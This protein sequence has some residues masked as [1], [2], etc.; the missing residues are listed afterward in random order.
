[1]LHLKTQCKTVLTY[2]FL[3]ELLLMFQT[4]V[5]TLTSSLQCEKYC[6]LIIT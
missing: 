3:A 4:F 6:H 5:L 1:M 2:F